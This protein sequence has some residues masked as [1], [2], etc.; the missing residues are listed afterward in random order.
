MCY[1]NLN[2][3]IMNDEKRG[4]FLQK[5]RKEKGLTQQ[6]LGDL[7]HYTDKAISKWERGQSLP[8]N[9]ETLEKLSQIFEVSIEELLY[10]ERK[11]IDNQEMIANNMADVYKKDYKKHK[12]LISRLLVIMLIFVILAMISMYFLF[13]K[14]KIH[15][16]SLNGESESFIIEN[17][18][19]LLTDKIDILNFGKIIPKADQT[20]NYIKLYYNYENKET[21]I[22]KGSNDNYYLEEYTGYEEYSLDCIPFSNLFVEINY[23]NNQ[24]EIIKVEI[25]E[26]FIN[27]KIFNK[28]IEKISA[29]PMIDNKS[30]ENFIEFLKN[31]E[32]EY[33]SNGYEKKINKNSTIYFIEPDEISII[34]KGKEYTENISCDLKYDEIIYEKIYN[35]GQIESKFYYINK[36]TENYEMNS[37][38]QSIDEYIMYISYLKNNY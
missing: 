7:I 32:F 31:E 25:T 23:N 14:G 36:K 33:G 11:N 17:T 37:N 10:G 20:I 9:P 38:F 8:N 18:S 29:T 15:S 35:D 22:F 26:K 34:I 1:N 24:K 13:I 5:L 6:G 30:A 19:L 3:D 27:D 12:K 4:L 16:Y 21:M 28:T 2:G